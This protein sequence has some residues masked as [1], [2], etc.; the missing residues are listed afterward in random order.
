MQP[1]RMPAVKFCVSKKRLGNQRSNRS[2]K[3]RGKEVSM[4]RVDL[5]FII[6]GKL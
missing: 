1:D 5:Y 2:A 3:L 6:S 4:G